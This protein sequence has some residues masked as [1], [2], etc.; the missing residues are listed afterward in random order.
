[1]TCTNSNSSPECCERHS[2]TDRERE[3]LAEHPPS[4]KLVYRELVIS[5]PLST[6]ELAEETTLPTRTVQHALKELAS[7]D[8]I[9]SRPDAEVP[10]RNVYKCDL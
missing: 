6:G 8:L 9:A 3:H 2:L 4:V 7:D 10:S 1:M 5:G